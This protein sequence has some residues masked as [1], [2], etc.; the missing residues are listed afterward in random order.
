MKKLLFTS[1]FVLA[2]ILSVQSQIS[3]SVDAFPTNVGGKTEFKR[4]F[5]SQFVY[6]AAALAK[7]QGGKVEVV[8]VLNSDSSATDVKVAVGV[9]PELDQEAL[10]LFKYYQWVPAVKDGKLV[11]SKWSVWFEFDPEKYAKIC[12]KRGYQS[13]V[14]DKEFKADSTFKLY[15][16]VDQ[17]PVYYKGNYALQDF[18]KENLE[19]PRQAQIA[20]IQGTVVVRFIVEQNGTLSNIGIEKSVGGGCNEE[21][22]RLVE[23]TRWRAGVV[24]DKWVRTQ[25]TLPIYFMLNEDFKDNSGSEQK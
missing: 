14:Y 23:M 17:M 9:S 16:I 8:F 1:V 6:P 22:I 2:L 10:R 24:G 12:K 13:I 20:N 21:A 5:E 18:L 3:Y 15:K 19:Y 11:S 25:M 4:I 7:K